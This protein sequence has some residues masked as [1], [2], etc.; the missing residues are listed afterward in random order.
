M[1]SSYRLL[2]YPEPESYK[3]L[4]TGKVLPGTIL[5]YEPTLAPRDKLSARVHLYHQPQLSGSRW[6]LHAND[7]PINDRQYQFYNN[8]EDENEDVPWERLEVRD[9][10]LVILNQLCQARPLF[11]RA[12]RRQ[13]ANNIVCY[14]PTPEGTQEALLSVFQRVVADIKGEQEAREERDLTIVPEWL[15]YVLTDLGNG[16]VIARNREIAAKKNIV[17]DLF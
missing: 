12:N 2:S 14:A 4:A 17:V 10:S 8:L 6:Y 1:N 7:D 5:I 15:D 11:N 3:D 13:A 16:L 9:L